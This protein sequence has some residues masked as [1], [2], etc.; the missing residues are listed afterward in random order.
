MA[1]GRPRRPGFAPR[2]IVM[3]KA[4]IAGAVKRRLARDIGATAALRFYRSTLARTLLVL[5]ADPRWR[6]YLAVTPDTSLRAPYWPPPRTIARIKQGAGDLGARMQ[7]LFDAMPPGPVVIV[8]SDIPAIRPTLY[9]ARLQAPRP[10]RR[11]VRPGAR[12]R[13][14]ACGLEEIAEA[15]FALRERSLVHG[16]G[17]RRHARQFARDDCPFRRDVERRRRESGLPP[18]AR[19]RDPAGAGPVVFSPVHGLNLIFDFGRPVHV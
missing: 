4:P 19:R 16:H 6:T 8:G 18:R 5:G 7:N 13:L 1:K 17:T 12:R 3:A 11:R 15:A 14:L 2:L 10:C 9:R